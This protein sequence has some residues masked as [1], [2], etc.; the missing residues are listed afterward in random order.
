[1]F[2]DTEAYIVVTCAY[3]YVY[4]LIDIGWCHAA[5]VYKYT[6]W[7]QPVKHAVPDLQ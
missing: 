2:V 3:A 5:W 6:T 1:M 7:Q 4:I